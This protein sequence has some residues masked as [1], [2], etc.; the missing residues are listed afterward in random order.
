MKGGHR[1]FP[2]Q[3]STPLRKVLKA[4]SIG[5]PNVVGSAG[6]HQVMYSADYDLM[7]EATLKSTSAKT[8][9]ALVKRTQ[10]VATITDI[11]CGE[12][13]AWNL[14]TGKYDREAEVKHL[15]QLWQ[16]G[17]LTEGEVQEAKKLLKEHLTVP[18]KLRARKELRFG[19]LR[20]TPAEVYAGHKTFRKHT[21]YLEDAFKSTGI[22][23]V[24]AVA[25]VNDK[26]IEV[27]NIILWHDGKKQF[28]QTK[29]LKD[30][31]AEDILL[32][33]DEENWVKVAKRMLS[34]AKE[35]GNLTD[36]GELRRVL[37]SPLGAVYTVVSDLELMEEFPDAMTPARK[38]KELDQMRD[39]MAKLYFP[40]FDH[41]SNPRALLPKLKDL[42]QEETKHQLE[43][44]RLL[45][46]R[47]DYRPTK[48]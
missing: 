27:S 14:L 38:R 6:D 24:D 9:Q 30:A 21:F 48:V 35:R 10:K 5:P 23:K 22:T 3:F 25:W 20:W 46:V 11:K 31:L 15:G 42:L 28:A 33:E 8:F 17:I 40:D 39:R 29:P 47:K 41:A 4:V 7:E 44:G 43:V 13:Q 36:E 45:P 18:E 19:V 34:L 16:D 2:D 1:P 26:Y 37:N 12:V 32:Y